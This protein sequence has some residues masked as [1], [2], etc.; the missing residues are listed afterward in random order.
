MVHEDFERFDH[1]VALDNSNLADL[2]S[3]CPAHHKHKLSL[4]L[5]HVEERRGEDVP[6]PYYGFHSFAQVYDIIECG[7]QG[8]FNHLSVSK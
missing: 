1:I 6:D 2:K 7:V 5:D 3:I 4:L 8:L